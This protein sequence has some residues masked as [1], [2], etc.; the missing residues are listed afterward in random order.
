LLF[1]ILPLI[2]VEAY[3]RFSGQMNVMAQR[4]FLLRYSMGL[5]VTLAVLV[6]GAGGGQQFIYFD[7]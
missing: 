3:Q 1:Y 7:F 6:L 5:A 2:A 4:P